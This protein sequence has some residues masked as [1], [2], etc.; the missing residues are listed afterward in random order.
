MKKFTFSVLTVAWA[1]KFLQIYNHIFYEFDLWFTMVK[2]FYKKLKFAFNP[3]A[4]K[5]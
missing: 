5:P 1:E 3:L 4:L 2:R